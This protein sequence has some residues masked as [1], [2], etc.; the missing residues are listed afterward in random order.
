MKNS[1]GEPREHLL[2]LQMSPPMSPRYP[3]Q[4]LMKSLVLFIAFMRRRPWLSQEASEAP[5]GR[6]SDTA[7]I[8]PLSFRSEFG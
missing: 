1:G 4:Q 3:L 2:I 8:L 5:C 6:L 7:L